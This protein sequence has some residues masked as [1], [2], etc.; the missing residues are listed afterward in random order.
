MKE[1]PE[2]FVSLQS[3]LAGEYSLERELGRGGMGIVY[4]ARDVQL[5]RLV[6]IKVLPTRF[7]TNSS[8]RERFVREAR[9]AA[10]LSHPH[11][12][13]IHRVGEAGGFVFFVMA[14]V[15]G[16]TLGE[17]LRN[18][19]PLPPTE[20]ERVMRE[21]AWALAY[22]HG[23]GIVHR[24]IKPDNILI[25][26]GT[27]RA[28]VTDFGIAHTEGSLTSGH[29][30]RIEGTA[31]FMSPEQAAGMTVDGRSDLYSLG[32]V[33]YLA[34]SG[35]M[36]SH[37]GGEG[38]AALPS[39]TALPTSVAR[40]APGVHAELASAIDRCLAPSP[41]ERFATCEALADALQARARVKRTLPTA[42][43]AWIAS[44]NP[45]DPAFVVVSGAFACYAVRML[46]TDPLPY[47]T[48]TGKL[49][50]PSGW[51]GKA[52]A[53]NLVGIVAPL[54]PMLGYHVAQARRLFRA[55]HSL[56]DL[57]EAI[58]LDEAE[59]AE[60]GDY[61][62]RERP[63]LLQR[64]LK[65]GT[66]ASVSASAALVVLMSIP[67]TM[68]AM[69]AN[70]FVSSVVASFVLASLGS[71]NG[72]RWLPDVFR[73]FRGL[74]AHLWMSR[75]G[76]WFARWLGA[77]AMSK[78]GDDAIYR[79]T[80]MALGVAASELFAALPELFRSQLADLPRIVEQL[81]ARASAARARIDELAK[82]KSV[83]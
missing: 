4:L 44:R 62:A 50:Y 19:G 30:V 57:R 78:T 8:L 24:D 31:R 40:V 69:T 74:R 38:A 76:A 27:G 80:E 32:V 63:T 2:E 58:V 16:Q 12:V 28:L 70:L 66:F 47:V 37:D 77:P 36:P 65:W 71:V 48:A 72:V 35:R 42:L 11:I 81:E 1:L 39:A 3:A 10:S 82:R 67:A 15:P 75:D 20:A 21:V 79:P 56:S 60:Q 6:A 54:L 52:W 68:T 17:R 5:E 59:R 26:H 9:T 83:V 23:H 73:T 7:A 45:L 64:V 29:P 14:Y 41:D 18:D 53:I 55:G 13:P 22:A 25:E 46:L 51:S 43:R 49:F 33:G 34:V 61:L